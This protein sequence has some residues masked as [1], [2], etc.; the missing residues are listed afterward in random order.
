MAGLYLFLEKK[1]Y[2]SSS[3]K[4]LGGSI[5]APGAGEIFQELVLANS[6]GIP[7]KGIIKKIYPYPT[8]ANMHKILLR[9]RILKD[10]K[11]WMKKLARK[12]YRL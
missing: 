1:R 12:F 4:I 11:P 5:M 10:I 7:L 8:A 3:A 9:N 2:N 6:A